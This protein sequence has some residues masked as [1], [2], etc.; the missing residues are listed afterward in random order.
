ML[1]RD[2]DVTF[3]DRA[4]QTAQRAVVGDKRGQG[5]VGAFDEGDGAEVGQ[6]GRAAGDVGEEV[7]SVAGG[8]FSARRARKVVNSVR[9]RPVCSAASRLA[10]ETVKTRS[11]VCAA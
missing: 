6:L 10:A 5:G 1:Q 7:A 2:G 8:S 11:A 3:T 4:A 9:S